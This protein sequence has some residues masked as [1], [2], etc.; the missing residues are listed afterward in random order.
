LQLG[1]CVRQQNG[2]SVCGLPPASPC[3]HHHGSA[4]GRS[5]VQP[6]V[7]IEWSML[8]TCRHHD[9]AAVFHMHALG[10]LVDCQDA[11]RLQQ[12][13]AGWVSTCMTFHGC[14]L[15]MPI[16]CL[17]KLTGC[18]GQHSALCCNTEQLT[19]SWESAIRA[20]CRRHLRV[21]LYSSRK[22]QR[23]TPDISRPLACGPRRGTPLM[24]PEDVGMRILL[25]KDKAT[26]VLSRQ[27]DCGDRN[28]R[29]RVPERL[30]AAPSSRQRGA[31]ICGGPSRPAGGSCRVSVQTAHARRRT[32]WPS[33]GHLGVSM[34][35]RSQ[36]NCATDDKTAHLCSEAIRPG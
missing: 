27:A 7:E 23:T 29:G 10:C 19:T 32:P 9:G 2:I 13:T 31:H 33:N 15:R 25:Q 28:G 8:L 34:L 3:S 35:L 24:V 22:E 30:P 4:I 6:K 12:V 18:D 20:M 11:P 16:D 14:L 5:G 21:S 1:C 36:C 26:A 17:P